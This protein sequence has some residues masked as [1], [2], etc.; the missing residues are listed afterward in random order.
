MKM[1]RWND[2]RRGACY[3]ASAQIPCIPLPVIRLEERPPLLGVDVGRG[4]ARVVKG[5]CHHQSVGARGFEVARS[6]P[7]M[8]VVGAIVFSQGKAE[9]DDHRCQGPLYRSEPDGALAD[10]VEEGGPGGLSIA[11][12][13]H[14]HSTRHNER[15]ALIRSCLFPE[16]WRLSIGQQTGNLGL[17]TGRQRSCRDETEEPSDQVEPGTRVAA[18]RPRLRSVLTCSQR[19]TG[20][21]D[22]T[23]SGRHRS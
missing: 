7:A 13:L 22:G 5:E 10:I 20:S 6:D 12:P 11:G 8:L 23:P 4:R 3:S 18:P 9:T 19:G 17:L 16:E 14:E 15:M 1:I 21:W 2:P